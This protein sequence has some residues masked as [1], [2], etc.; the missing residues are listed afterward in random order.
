MKNIQSFE[1][2]LNESFK[3][4]NKMTKS[5]N[6][7]LSLALK[8]L[9]KNVTSN[10]EL[11]NGNGIW[12]SSFVTPP[13]IKNKTGVTDYNYITIEFSKP[14]GKMTKLEVGLKKNTSGPGSGYIALRPLQGS[15][16]PYNDSEL[17]NS[18][19]GS[20]AIEFYEDAEEMLGELYNN[21]IKTII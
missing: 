13:T 16:I 3:T 20:V 10:I 5:D 11:V 7:I 4:S 6:D 17:I 8:G 1:E 15:K 21:K 12:T 18:H 14:I 9:P 19:R 2:F